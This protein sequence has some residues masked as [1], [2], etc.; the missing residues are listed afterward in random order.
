MINL[1]YKLNGEL[2]EKEFTNTDEAT[3][4][5]LEHD[6]VKVSYKKITESTSVIVTSDIIKNSLDSFV[7]EDFATEAIQEAKK[8]DKPHGRKLSHQTLDH[9][10]KNEAPKFE[11]LAAVEHALSA[12]YKKNGV[13]FTPAVIKQAISS[14]KKRSELSE[15]ELQ[16]VALSSD[17]KKAKDKIV[18]KLKKNLKEF[19]RRYKDK[20]EAEL[21]NLAT[22]VVKYGK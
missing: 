17:E 22:T 2:L 16:E 14:Y 4:F 18:L 5:M 21:Q 15:A 9:F 11:T 19:R 13:E 1:S 12:L 10:F 8:Y 3:Q 6:V 20:D 7:L